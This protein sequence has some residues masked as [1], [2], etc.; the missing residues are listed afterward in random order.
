MFYKKNT[1]EDWDN[2]RIIKLAV[3][4]EVLD[5]NNKENEYGWVWH[6]TPPQEYL[7]WVEEQQ[8]EEEEE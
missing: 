8:I 5:E 1:N 6:D 7:D 3:T 4:G 2:A